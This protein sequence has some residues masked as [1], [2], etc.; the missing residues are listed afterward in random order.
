LGSQDHRDIVCFLC[1][2][3]DSEGDGRKAAC[4][5]DKNRPPVGSGRVR[6]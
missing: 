4:C 5:G 6:H 2:L 3:A 1:P